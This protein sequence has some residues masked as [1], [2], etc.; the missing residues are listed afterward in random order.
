[1]SR[2]NCI[3]YICHIK[4]E[5]NSIYYIII[6]RI[7]HPFIFTLLR[8]FSRSLHVILELRQYSRLCER[9]QTTNW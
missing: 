5:N 1:M 3:L 9:P 6:A 4:N 2:L 8:V 7:Q